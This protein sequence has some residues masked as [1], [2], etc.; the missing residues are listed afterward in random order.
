MEASDSKPLLIN[1]LAIER[2]M[3]EA[4]KEAFREGQRQRG[5]RLVTDLTSEEA[6]EARE[7]SPILA[8]T[9]PEPE[10]QESDTWT[11]RATRKP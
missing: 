6:E 1:Q 10:S 9:Q 3:P 2:S 8:E 5:F 4:F 7:E 11:R